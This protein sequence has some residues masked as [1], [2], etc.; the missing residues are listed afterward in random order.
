MTSTTKDG[1][2]ALLLPAPGRYVV[3]VQASLA[4]RV[5][6]DSIEVAPAAA[7]HRELRVP[8]PPDPVFYDYQVEEPVGRSPG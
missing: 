4:P 7:V 6:R 3:P 8:M 1:V 5:L 2:F